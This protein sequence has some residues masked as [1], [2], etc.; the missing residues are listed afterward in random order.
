MKRFFQL[1]LCLLVCATVTLP[2][3]SQDK[4][5]G[6]RIMENTTLTAD[7]GILNAWGDVQT[8]QYYHVW[9]NRNENQ[10]GAGLT[11]NYWIKNTFYVGG[12]YARGRL[13]GTKRDFGLAKTDFNSTGLYFETLLSETSLRAG[14]NPLN[15]IKN[16][17]ER[18]LILDVNIGHGLCYYESL[19][20]K[21]DGTPYIVDK[22]RGRTGPTTEGVSTLGGGIMYKIN[23][24]Y[25]VGLS[26]SG[27]F[28][29]NDKLDA[30]IAIGS[31]NDMYS[32]TSL[33]LTYH[34]NPNKPKPIRFVEKDP[35]VLPEPDDTLIAKITEPVEPI[36]TVV[37]V[38]VTTDPPKEPVVADPNDPRQPVTPITPVTP[39]EPVTPEPVTPAEPV[40]PTV[41]STDPPAGNVETTTTTP[42]TN[43]G[44]NGGLGAGDVSTTN[45]DIPW[46]E[47]NGYFVVVGCFKTK[48]NAIR[49]AVRW[50]S[51]EKAIMNLDSKS[52]T[53]YM[54]AVE[55]YDTKKEA[56]QHMNKVRDSGRSPGAWVHIKL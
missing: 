40:T 37:K 46:S 17:P 44:G 42:T 49:E 30:W 35:E 16:N 11:L 1:L 48:D 3:Y 28:V 22:I 6:L 52:G 47:A 39:V 15:L 5:L 4:P 50:K 55:R 26:T 51:E 21:L 7:L 33:S 31:A 14:F 10:F 29:W 20:Y 9:T 38:V 12:H 56:L 24:K 45:S 32:F 41:T 18:R 34:L 54:V 27:R 25:D 43:D 2:A 19:L 53:W 23:H 8:Y 13:V 36:D